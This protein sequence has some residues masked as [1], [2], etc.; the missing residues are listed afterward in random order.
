[1]N[2]GLSWNKGVGVG[3]SHWAIIDY[4]KVQPLDPGVG[5]EESLRKTN[6]DIVYF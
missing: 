4:P 6:V 5:G 3:S 2:K 1:M